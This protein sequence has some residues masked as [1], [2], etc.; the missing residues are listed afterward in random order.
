[1]SF[2]NDVLWKRTSLIVS[3]KSEYP[4]KANDYRFMFL[5]LCKIQCK[6]Y[7]VRKK[8]LE[9]FK[10]YTNKP[11]ARVQSRSS[12]WSMWYRRSFPCKHSCLWTDNELQDIIQVQTIQVC[13][14]M[15]K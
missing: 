5:I 6:V 9:L 7:K 1:M 4:A 13:E 15:E 3:K 14:V 10:K 8:P 12:W 2:F 11:Y